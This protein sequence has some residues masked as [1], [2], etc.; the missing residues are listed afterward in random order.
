LIEEQIEAAGV[1]LGDSCSIMPFQGRRKAFT[2][3]RSCIDL[4]SREF[5]PQNLS[6]SY[7]ELP[8][9]QGGKFHYRLELDGNEEQGRFVLKTITG[10]PF[11]LN[12]LAAREAYVERQDRLYLE[13]HKV[14]FSQQDLQQMTAEHFE[15]PLLREQ[16][17]LE[18]EL[19]ILIEGETGT[20]KSHLARGV[21]QRSGRRGEFVAVNLS[22]YNPQLI[23]SELF[24]HKK[25]A[26]TGAISDK[27]GAFA[28]AT[29]G[30]LFLDEIDSLPLELQTKLLTF[31]DNRRY[32]PVGEVREVALRTRLV[33]AAGQRLEQLVERG[34]FRKDLFYRLR[35]GH[36]VQLLSLR[37]DLARIRDTCQW[38]GLSRGV[39]LTERLLDFYQSLAWPGNL[40]QLLGHLEKKKVLSRSSKLDFDHVDE[41][42]LLQSSDLMSLT[43][44]TE[45]VPM[46]RYKQEYVGRVVGLCEGNVAL[47]A[48]KL[49]LSEKTVR[50]MLLRD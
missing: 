44:G 25:G 10:R 22:S 34:G 26:F 9:V 3:R 14:D 29:E 17:I 24:G 28:A 43:A 18:S 7:I 47:A 37:N 41:E 5:R 49:R 45:I 23:E 46:D 20:G 48:R 1:R 32:R 50:S 27:T 11:W 12:G 6:M 42:L 38:F 8:Q 13:D 19:N 40:R 33:F 31:L 2:L 35:S 36:S 30:T 39:S 21:H 4:I 15:H 16:K